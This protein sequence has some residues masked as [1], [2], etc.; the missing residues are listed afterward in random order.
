MDRQVVCQTHNYTVC[1][2]ERGGKKEGLRVVKVKGDCEVAQA[3]EKKNPRLT[4]PSYFS[5][6]HGKEGEGGG[7]DKGRPRRRGRRGSIREGIF[8]ITRD[9]GGPGSDWC[10]RGLSQTYYLGSS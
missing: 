7:G 9:A 8:V 3:R 1:Y 10:R 6:V 5:V 2:G 4:S